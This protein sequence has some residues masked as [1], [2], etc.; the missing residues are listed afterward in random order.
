MYLNARQNG[1]VAFCFI[2]HLLDYVFEVGLD[3]LAGYLCQLKE[4]GDVTIGYFLE[5]SSFNKTLFDV[6][7]IKCYMEFSL[8]QFVQKMAEGAAGV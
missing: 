5:Q 8:M 3:H 6:L 2:H 7:F 1:I 4:I